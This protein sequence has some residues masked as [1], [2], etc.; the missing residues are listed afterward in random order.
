[1]GRQPA[2]CEDG[3]WSANQVADRL[4][5]PIERIRTILRA[6]NEADF[7]TGRGRYRC[8]A[9]ADIVTI[10]VADRL[11]T[12]G[13]RPAR[14][15][16]ACRYLREQLRV[17]GPPLT[18]HTFFTD[19]RTVLVNTANPESVVDVANQGQLVFA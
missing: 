10:L 5:I 16:D 2:Q 6:L 18:G 1:M 11:I 17:T 8:F 9:P 15:R 4:H 3:T 14:V 19:G 12:E 13:V 7:G